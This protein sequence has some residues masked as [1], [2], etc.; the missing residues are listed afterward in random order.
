MNDLQQEKAELVS[1]LSRLRGRDYICAHDRIAEKVQELV[2]DIQNDF[3]TVVVLGEFKRGKSTFVNALLGTSLLPMDI[4][5]ETATINAI[6]YH[7]EPTLQVVRQD[8]SCESG[9]VTAEYLKRFSARQDNNEAANVRYIKIGYPAEMLKNRI[10]LVDTPGVSDLDE[11]R[12]DVTYEF[13]PKANAVLFLLDANSPLKKS[14]KDFIEERLLPQGID[15]IIFLLNKYDDVD[16]DEDEDLLESTQE[17]LSKA[18]NRDVTVYPVSARW[19]LEGLEQGNHDLVEAS[20]INVVREQFMKMVGQGRVEYAK[21][22]GWKNRLRAI[23]TCIRQEI[24]NDIELCRMDQQDVQKILDELD[25]LLAEK[26]RNQQSIQT[27]VEAR[28]EEINVMTAKSLQYFNKQLKEDILDRIEDYKGADF[29]TF[30]EKKVTRRI[31]R[32][33]EAWT[34]MYGPHINQLLENMERELSCGISYYFKQRICLETER[35]HEVHA[36]KANINIVA[37]DV[38]KATLQAGTYAAAGGIA[39]MAVIG[40]AIMPLVG[41]VAAP[42]LSTY[43]LEKKLTEAKAAVKP[44]ISAQLAKAIMKLSQEVDGYVNERCEL[45]RQ[46]TEYAYERVLVDFRRNL[47]QQMESQ[48]KSQADNERHYTRLKEEEAC[49]T[50]LY[51][52]LVGNAVAR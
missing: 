28:K 48:R 14:E 5:P 29:K 38:S 2:T 52:E 40:G 12:C 16:E 32:Q 43:M 45:I 20:Q 27:Y 21:I 17:R 19:A 6:M 4:L 34:G 41:L 49:M 47:Q 39:L 10:I 8:G 18:F 37:Q 11:Q 23:L 46:N 13:I 44:E 24:R 1:I 30:V 50:A 26:Q 51:E 22:V 3:Y 25:A 36:R 15:N 42:R 9:E 7:E 31:Q 33:L 35:G